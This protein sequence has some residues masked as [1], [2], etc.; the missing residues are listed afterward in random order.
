MT[1]PAP[2][3]ATPPD[4]ASLAPL[5][6][7]P[8]RP[9]AGAASSR[10][11]ADLTLDYLLRRMRFKSDFPALSSSVSRVQALAQSETDSMQALCD[12]V[13]RDVALTQKI[14]RVVNTAHFRRAG[15]DPI[16]TISRA[17]ALIGAG[18]VRNMALS[19]MLLE[20]MQDKA[21]VQQLRTEFLRTVMAGTLAS[22]LSGTSKEAE[23]AY[24][25]AMFRNLGRLLVAFYLP[26]D[27]EQ[28]RALCR[29]SADKPAP[30]EEPEAAQ[31]VLGVSFDQLADKVGQMWG[32]PDD[33]R[34]CMVTPRG[35]VPRR[36][37][38]GRPDH[39][40]WLASLSS[41][42]TEA[43]MHTEPSHL[44]DALTRLQARYASALDLH[45]SELQD[46]AGRARQRMTELT[47]ALGFAVPNQPEAERLVDPY[48][49][50]APHGATADG[51]RSGA[52]VVPEPPGLPGAATADGFASPAYE[53]TQVS[54]YDGSLS[55]PEQSAALAQPM[56]LPDQTVANVLT[57]G[58]QDLTNTLLESFK[59]N[60]VLHM[61]LE[62]M[63]RAMQCQRVVFCLRDPRSNQLVG[64]MGIGEDIDVVK[65]AFKVP[66]T[67]AAGQVPDLFSVVCLKQADLLV[68]D[69]SVGGVAS[70]LPRW[71][72]Q[73]VG[74]PS[75][76]LLPLVL[77]RKGQPELVLGLIYAD[78]AQARGFQVRDRELSLLRTLRN[79]AVMAFKQTTGQ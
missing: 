59:L 33:L 49:V 37:L 10:Q 66:L 2:V 27:A 46:A 57:N 17:V 47:A 43:L 13:L 22:E 23:Q 32:L 15:T 39:Q 76:L 4:T 29:P 60:D 8:A 72:T 71:F 67:I 75:F 3:P 55:L 53:R 50:D 44:G 9:P 40:W 31:Q 52:A 16:S 79:Q 77:K 73:H 41:A 14:L 34:Q 45:G 20:H 12:E 7:G 63:Y 6:N 68:D 25:G 24:L 26:E 21:H 48:Y 62:T 74:A 64:R 35:E 51:E 69:A 54:A 58:I 19:L 30:M 61:I 42:A 70:K 18:G 56:P 5:L 36:S 38:K 11:E 1:S 28:I 65:A 78:H